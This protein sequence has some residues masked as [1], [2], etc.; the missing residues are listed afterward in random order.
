MLVSADV[1][2]DGVDPASKRSTP[3][4]D[5]P[6]GFITLTS[7]VSSA[8]VIPEGVTKV[9]DVELVT[10]TD[11]PLNSVPL[12]PI[13]F[14]CVVPTVVKLEPVTVIVTPDAVAVVGDIDDTTG[15]LSIDFHWF[16]S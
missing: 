7:H 5:N 8:T 3:I 11:V 9:N 14:T 15:G 2:N 1:E 6:D 16:P 12:S 4:A 13:S 10:F